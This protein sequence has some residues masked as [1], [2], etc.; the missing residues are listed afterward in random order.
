MNDFER[1]RTSGAD[2]HV[3]VGGFRGTAEPTVFESPTTETRRSMLVTQRLTFAVLLVY[4]PFQKPIQKVMWD[5]A[6][7]SLKPFTQKDLALVSKSSFLWP[8]TFISIHL[9][10]EFS[11][12]QTP[13]IC[14]QP[15]GSATESEA[16]KAKIRY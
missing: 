13:A 9:T 5:K 14:I 3:T 8:R 4:R 10:D 15:V 7:D 12:T 1:L 11:R 2:Q 16:L 6:H